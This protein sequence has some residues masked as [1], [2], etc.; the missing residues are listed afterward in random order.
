MCTHTFFLQPAAARRARRCWSQR[1]Q[2]RPSQL[3]CQLPCQLSADI[4]DTFSFSATDHR[5]G[6]NLRGPSPLTNH[7]DGCFLIYK[8]GRPVVP[9]TSRSTPTRAHAARRGKP[10]VKEA[11]RASSRLTLKWDNSSAWL[12][13]LAVAYEVKVVSDRGCRTPSVSAA[14]GPC[15]RSPR[16]A[17]LDRGGRWGASTTTLR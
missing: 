9:R 7:P 14:G 5:G 1:H 10:P 3:P 12:N 16:R 4:L 13:A 15:C 17:V 2:R 8:N 6:L 11:S